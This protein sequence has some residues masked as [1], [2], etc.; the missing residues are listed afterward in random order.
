M[1]SRIKKN[2]DKTSEKDKGKLSNIEIV[3]FAVYLLGG[4]TG[5]VDTEDIAIKASELAPGKFT[6]KK[7]REQ[8]NIDN[9]RKRLSD[10]QGS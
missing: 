6:W 8:V 2:K 9:I 5:P 4:E 7:Y 1:T 3:T 10:A